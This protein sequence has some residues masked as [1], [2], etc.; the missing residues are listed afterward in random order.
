MKESKEHRGGTQSCIPERAHITG[1]TSE[2][3]PYEYY[4]QTGRH[5]D[6]H[7]NEKRPDIFLPDDYYELPYHLK[8]P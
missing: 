2:Y 7:L 6:A 3:K 8:H 4:G 1:K 5:T